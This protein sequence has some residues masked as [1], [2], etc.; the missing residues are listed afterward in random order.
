P[1]ARYSL[2][3][4]ATPFA[5][6]PG[7]ND[8][9]L[10]SGTMLPRVALLFPEATT[11][12]A[13]QASALDDE[14]RTLAT[15][16]QSFTLTGPLTTAAVTL[17]SPGC[18]LGGDGGGM[19]DGGGVAVTFVSGSYSG[20]FQATTNLVVRGP[21]DVQPGDLLI[22]AVESDAGG[23]AVQAPGAW[24]QFLVPQTYAV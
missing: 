21:S 10:V 2:S 15:G 11:S 18:N 1:V 5:Q 19:P 22:L 9:Y 3:V 16:V 17:G 8:F 23:G 6:A 13:I 4:A 20:F 14:D 7:G 12:V 24:A